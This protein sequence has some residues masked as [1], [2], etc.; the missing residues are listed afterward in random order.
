MERNN[1]CLLLVLFDF[2]RWFK[3]SLEK[4]EQNWGTKLPLLFD[5]FVCLYSTFSIESLDRKVFIV[6][7]VNK[8]M[9]CHNHLVNIEKSV[10]ISTIHIPFYSC[11]F[12][13]IL[14]WFP[15]GMCIENVS[16]MNQASQNKYFFFPI[17]LLLSILFP[18]LFPM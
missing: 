7:S 12:V 10:R 14:I 2:E 4:N 18:S 11:L 13:K 17:F 6:Q 5:S 8:D 1:S 16:E 9:H 15:V 3:A